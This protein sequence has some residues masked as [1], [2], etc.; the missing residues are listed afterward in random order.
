MQVP[1]EHSLDQVVQYVANQYDSLLGRLF[2]KHFAEDEAFAETRI[3]WSHADRLR[4]TGAFRSSGLYIWG[5]EKCPIY[6]GMTA[7]QTFEGRF[8]RYVWGTNSQCNLAGCDG[9][10]EGGPLS[11][12]RY[13]NGIGG[14]VT[15]MPRGSEGP[16]DLR[17]RGWT[18]SGSPYFQ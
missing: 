18:R 17:V 16:S 15:P 7:S 6:I 9:V 8:G 14:I 3:I 1:A 2:Q 4:K 10:A 13:S 12:P 5:V 11:R